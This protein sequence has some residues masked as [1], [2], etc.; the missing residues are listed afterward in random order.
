MKK[1]TL[2]ELEL[3]ELENFEEETDSETEVKNRLIYF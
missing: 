1:P 2:R 3:E